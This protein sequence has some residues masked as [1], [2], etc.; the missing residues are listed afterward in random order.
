MNKLLIKITT[1]FLALIVVLFITSSFIVIASLPFWLLWNW[2]MPDIFGLPNITLLQSFG[3]WTFMV[4]IR[5]T[6]FDYKQTLDKMKTEHTDKE[7]LE[8]NQI[9]NSIKKNYTA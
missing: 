1:W 9:F 2:L 7:E 8:W 5:S 6:K 3:L 4:L